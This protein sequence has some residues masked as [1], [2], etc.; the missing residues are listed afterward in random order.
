[1][2][3]TAILL[4]WMGDGGVRLPHDY[5]VPVKW[6]GLPRLY[7]LIGAF[8]VVFMAAIKM[9]PETKPFVNPKLAA[10]PYVW[11]EGCEQKKY[12]ET[13]TISEN[14]LTQKYYIGDGQKWGWRRIS[15]WPY[16]YRVG[17]D[18]VMITDV[19]SGTIMSDRPNIV[20]VVDDVFVSN[21]TGDVK[22]GM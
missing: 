20:E 8:I 15:A 1:M 2:A 6:L 17:N 11:P 5:N 9:A 14:C 13:D 22:N 16:Y 21:N 12:R 3:G 10:E 7:W 18:A 19:I 4:F